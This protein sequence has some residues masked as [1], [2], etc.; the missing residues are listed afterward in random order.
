MSN[1]KFSNNPKKSKF[2]ISLGQLMILPMILVP[3][4][5]LITDYIKLR[6]PGVDFGELVHFWE[7]DQELC[8]KA[9]TGYINQAVLIY[10]SCRK[11]IDS[12]DNISTLNL[13][14][15]NAGRAW[16]V[17]W[18]QS[19]QEAKD[20]NIYRAIKKVKR[21]FSVA[22]E[23]NQ[24]DPLAKF[25]S[26]YMEDFEDVVQTPE[27]LDCLPA[28]ERYQEVIKLYLKGD[29]IESVGKDFFAVLKLA[30]FLVARDANQTFDL[31]DESWDDLNGYQKAIELY[32]KL[33]VSDKD[34]NSQDANYLVFLDQGKAY[35]LDGNYP[36]AEYSW[37]KAL[38]IKPE[39]Y[40][41]NYNRGNLLALQREYGNAIKRYDAVT[42]DPNTEEYYEALRNSGFAHYI[43]NN[44]KEAKN[45]FQRALKIL[46]KLDKVNESDVELMETYLQKIKDGQ[47]EQGVFLY[48][49]CYQND[50]TRKNVEKD[51]KEKGIFT[52]VYKDRYRTKDK[53]TDPFLEVEHDKFDKCRIQPEF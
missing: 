12:T 5:F 30:H 35:F 4:I 52:S 3:I 32:N 9:P 48:T 8:N 14:Y 1:E 53:P 42:E 34:A 28:S 6:F 45:R 22:E 43:F 44:Y 23:L 47:C 36:W 40:Q 11:V 10:E 38:D 49:S 41:I 50:K 39:D 2:S 46:G 24:K 7:S 37:A 17:M 29:N 19:I 13:E 20:K 27:K 33:Q 21:Y 18:D 26:A 25:Y 51:I 16:F 31:G 15:K